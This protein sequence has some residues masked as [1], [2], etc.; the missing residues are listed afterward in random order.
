MQKRG[1]L[2]RFGALIGNWWAIMSLTKRLTFF[3]AGYSQVAI[4]FPFVVAAPRY[5]AG[6]HHR[7]AG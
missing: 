5:F 4:I 6:A 1:L 2:D 3:T 7:S